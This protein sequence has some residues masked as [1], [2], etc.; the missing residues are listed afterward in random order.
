M[1]R[2]LFIPNP[3]TLLWL[4]QAETPEELVNAVKQGE[5]KPPAPY[6]YLTGKLAAYWQ[7]GLVI[8]TGMPLNTDPAES[9]P[10]FS[11]RNREILTGL[12]DGLTTRQIALRLGVH[13]RTIYNHIAQL[14]HRLGAGTRAELAAKARDLLG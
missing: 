12:L 6:A 11:R 7:E 1:T 4:D 8:V 3:H 2:L 14:K 10:R 9:R 5:W 13:P